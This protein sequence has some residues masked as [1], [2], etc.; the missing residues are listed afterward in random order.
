MSNT[1]WKNDNHLHG[2][3]YFIALLLEEEGRFSFEH[4]VCSMILFDLE[5]LKKSGNPIWTMSQIS[6]GSEKYSFNFLDDAIN[7]KL[8]TFNEIFEL[9][10]G[11]IFFSKTG[12]DH[13]LC[14]D[15]FG[16]P[17]SIEGS[18][19]VSMKNSF[20]ELLDVFMNSTTTELKEKINSICK[21]D[22]DNFLNFAQL[23]K[24]N[25][26]PEGLYDIMIDRICVTETLAKLGG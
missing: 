3:W 19:S 24:K 23:V 16:N 22:G 14:D 11:E 15:Y 2:Y 26:F 21:P 4:A 9:K 10:D 8:E 12:R 6:V 1:F 5:L 13:Y 20:S 17:Y 18:S 25:E 7:G